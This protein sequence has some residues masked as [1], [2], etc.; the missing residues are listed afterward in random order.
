MRL[1]DLPTE[2]ISHI[3]SQWSSANKLKLALVCKKLYRKISEDNLYQKL[4]FRDKQKLDQAIEQHK[5]KLWS[6]N[7]SSLYWKNG[8]RCTTFISTSNSISKS[9]QQ[10]NL[11]VLKLLG[12]VLKIS[13]CC[14]KCHKLGNNRLKV[15]LTLPS[16]WL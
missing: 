1:E 16:R 2:I 5:K 7:T 4:V 3:T 6:A 10:V 14:L 8:F 13:R 15:L 9:N 11:V 12:L